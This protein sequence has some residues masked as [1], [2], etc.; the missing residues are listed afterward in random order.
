MRWTMLKSIALPDVTEIEVNAFSDCTELKKVVL[1]NLTKVYDNVGK[2]GTFYG[3]KTKDID[4]VLSK[5]QKVM[6]GGE[7]AEAWYCWTAAD[8]VYMN[9]SYHKASQFLE[10]DFK[11]VEC[12]TRIYYK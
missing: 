12:G 6:N 7:T 3:C 11:S 5:D 9:S 1:G 10:Y 2:N 4:L 8:Q